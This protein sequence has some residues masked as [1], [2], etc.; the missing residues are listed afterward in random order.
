MEK[1]GKDQYRHELKFLIAESEINGIKKRLEPIMKLDV[2]AGEKGYFIRSLYF[3]DIWFS[4]LED[5]LA[6]IQ[7]RSKYR[8]RIYDYSDSIIKL[9]CKRK[10]GQYI[11]KTDATISSIELQCLEQGNYQFLAN[12]PEKI[13]HEFYYHCVTKKMKPSIMVDYERVPYIYSYGD[14]RVTFDSHVRAGFFERNI[15]DQTIPVYEVLDPGTLILE[16]K[17][18]EYLPKII[19]DIL[20]GIKSEHIAASKYV[21]C[22]EKQNEI[23]KLRKE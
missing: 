19:T 5:K 13:C 6:G 17:Y 1:N 18:T 22:L 12:R 11:N 16:V 21:M 9:E 10:E 8:I 4:A 7:K 3:D 15:W 2:H 14:V 23:L 20:H